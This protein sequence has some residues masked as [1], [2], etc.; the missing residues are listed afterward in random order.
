MK[1]AAHQLLFKTPVTTEER[2]SPKVSSVFTDYVV[3]CCCS[4]V[5]PP[6]LPTKPPIS[7]PGVP[8]LAVV[9]THMG[10]KNKYCDILQILYVL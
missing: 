1:F 10:V 6:A 8:P 7:V 2:C 5:P 4:I 3:S 9:S